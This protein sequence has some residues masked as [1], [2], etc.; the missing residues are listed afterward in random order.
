MRKLIISC[1]AMLAACSI[2]DAQTSRRA[3]EAEITETVKQVTITGR[4]PSAEALGKLCSTASASIEMLSKVND[5]DDPAQAKAAVRIIE[6]LAAYTQK[7]AGTQ[8]TDEVRAGLGKAVDR[9]DDTD[10]RQRLMEALLLCAKPDDAAHIAMYLADPDMSLTAFQGLVAMK[11]IDSQLDSLARSTT[12][13]DPLLVQVQKARAGKSVAGPKAKAVKRAAVA[14]FWTSSLDNAFNDLRGIPDAVADSMLLCADTQGAFESLLRRARQKQGR[15]RDAVLARYVA[16]TERM[17]GSGAERYLL[18]RD[19]DMLA[20]CDD[21]RRRIIVDLGATHTVQ[22]MAYI[23]QYYDSPAM[24]DATAVA[25]HDIIANNMG[26]NGGKHVRNMLNAA[27][28][29]YIRHY[30]E[31]GA[32][33][34]IDDVLAAIDEC[35]SEGGYNLA[36]APDT[37]MGKRGYWNM[38]DELKDFD[39]AFDWNATGT[40]VV[41]LRSMPVLT[42]NRKSGAKVAGDTR[43][44]TFGSNDAWCTANVSVDGDKLTVSVNGTV[45]ADGVQLVNPQQ[46]QPVRQS[47]IVS[48]NADDAGATVRQV[49]IRRR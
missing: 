16:L 36:T 47:G 25:T 37:R 14:P 31:E 3:L 45:I 42:L 5:P 41:S 38:Y 39:M 12:P 9:C 27:K 44:H 30:D 40:L 6:A 11:G 21:L 18:L 49:C 29:A 48:F 20:P 34:A 4:T 32:D 17:G 23:R 35:G 33:K 43:W 22:A 7:S 13:P 8:Y 46:G 19:A 2:A 24:A 28:Q 26:V 15:D 1:L 10:T